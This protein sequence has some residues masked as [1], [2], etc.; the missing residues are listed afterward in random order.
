MF[1]WIIVGSKG[2]AMR[3]KILQ[4]I[5]ETPMNAHQVSEALRVNYR[6]ATFHLDVMAK[7]GLVRTGGPRYG[8][9]YFPSP[10][11]MAHKDLLRKVI[12]GSVV[13]AD[14][15]TDIAV[16]QLA[17]KDENLPYVKIGDSE[18]LKV[19]QIA[20]AIRNS[21]G[22]PGGPTVSLGVI[23]ALGRPLPGADFIY[24]GF[25]QTDAAVNPGNS[26]GPLSNLQGEVV[27]INTAIIPFANGMGFAI[28]INIVKHV[29]EQI[30]QKG[31]VIRPWIGV[32]AVDITSSISHRFDLAVEWGVLIVGV[33]R[34]S[35]ADEAGIR[36]RDVILKVNDKEIHNMKDLI[37][38]L[39][40][41]EVGSK[42]NLTVS[43]LG[44][45]REVSLRLIEI[46]VRLAEGR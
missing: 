30:L 17:A 14:K 45:D 7:N 35:P 11:C 21:L 43:R 28:P 37:S 12:K 42:I 3:A 31:R 19:G 36:Q 34:Y 46:P 22:L 29:V 25:V 4:L 27:G 8:L 13:G 5:C 18:Q 16:I 26:G 32:S 39:S 23:G 33:S 6:T 38:D 24:D 44:R 1:W 20:L 41:V 9:V 15:A 10:A 2:G 40:K